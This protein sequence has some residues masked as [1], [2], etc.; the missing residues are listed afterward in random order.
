MSPPNKFTKAQER[1]IR[2]VG[3]RIERAREA[4]RMTLREAAERTVTGSRSGHMTDAT[5]RRVELGYTQ[6]KLGNITYR[7]TP[8]TLAA[9]AE[10]VGLDGD[11]LCKELEL[12][13]PPPL[14]RRDPSSEI[15]EIKN[16]LLQITERL[17]RLD[18]TR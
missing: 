3:Q 8:R 12:T 14:V 16:Q 11:E 2:E 18:G 13:P 6:T 17:S 7:A 5:W 15:E 1:K 9:M 10:V 4:R